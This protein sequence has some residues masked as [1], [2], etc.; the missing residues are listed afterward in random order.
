MTTRLR[1]HWRR[2]RRVVEVA[3]FVF[4][5]AKLVSTVIVIG[6]IAHVWNL[7]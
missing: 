7:L 5:T 6:E 2:F 1:A 4:D 3:G